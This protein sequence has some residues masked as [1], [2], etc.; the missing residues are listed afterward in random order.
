MLQSRL[1][2]EVGIPEVYPQLPLIQ[3]SMVVDS[4]PMLTHGD[5]VKKQHEDSDIGFLVPL[6]KADKLKKYVVKEMDSTEI[7]VFLK[8]RKNLFL[9][10][11][12]LYQKVMLKNHPEPLYQICPT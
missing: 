7:R 4:S 1:G 8:Y 5:W 10:N 2:T 3:E 9:K 12:L 11:G 6:L